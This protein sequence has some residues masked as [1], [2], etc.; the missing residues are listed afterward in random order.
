MVVM[1]GREA[2]T[3]RPR[4]NRNKERQ[5][6]RALMIVW[7][8]DAYGPARIGRGITDEQARAIEIAE[9]C[10]RSGQASV[11]KVEGARLALGVP[12]L[13]SEY[14]RTGEGWRGRH[15]DSGTQW[16]PFTLFPETPVS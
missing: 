13:T 9:Q 2:W 12:G 6:N 5:A 8:W 10:L 1:R 14:Q 11:V 7:L 16:E 4:P 3:S 15:A